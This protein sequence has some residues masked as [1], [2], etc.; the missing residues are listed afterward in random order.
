MTNL[1]IVIQTLDSLIALEKRYSCVALGNY[2]RPLLKNPDLD[3]AVQDV[4]ETY[5]NKESK[6]N[7]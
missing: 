3:V 1:E 2:V 4:R 5:L 7:V 6:S